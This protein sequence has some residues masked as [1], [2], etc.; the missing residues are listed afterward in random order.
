VAL[1]RPHLHAVYQDSQ[2]RRASEP[3]LT[4]RQWELLRLVAAGHS[5][6]DIAGELFL[7]EHTVRKHLEN[8][9]ERLGVSSR[10]AAIARAF[11]NRNVDEC[12]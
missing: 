9:Y 3:R 6:A 8:I 5:N 10:T 2:R 11:Q 4:T 1:L 12:G 7:S